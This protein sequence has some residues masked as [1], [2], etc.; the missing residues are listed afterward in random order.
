MKEETEVEA[1]VTFIE[2]E[3]GR[4]VIWTVMNLE[5]QLKSI[6]ERL[7]MTKAPDVA[8]V[9]TNVPNRVDG[10][11]I[12]ASM[13]R[14]CSD[15]EWKK[16]IIA[17]MYKWKGSNTEWSSCKDIMLLFIKDEKVLTGKLST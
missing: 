6:W 4:T 17:L 10:F 14:V 9:T 2:I 3:T 13:E 8:G 15:T 11:V 7:R 5:E 12:Q 1:I 16:T